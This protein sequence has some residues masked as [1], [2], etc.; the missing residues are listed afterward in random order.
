MITIVVPV[1]NE[2]SNITPLVEEIFDAAKDLP[3]REVLFVDDSSTDGSWDILKKL[4]SRY[5]TLNIIR[6]KHNHGQSAALWTGIKAAENDIIVTLDGDGQNPP[7]DIKTLWDAYHRIK[8]ESPRVMIAGERVKRNDTWIRRASSRFA[9]GLRSGL[10]KD[11][12][13]DTGCSLKLF[14]RSDY[15]A[16]PYFDHMHRF[17]PALM[18]RDGVDI[19]HVPVSHRPR[20]H[21]VS[22][23]GTLDRALVGIVDLLGVLW[24]QKRASGNLEYESI[25]PS[26]QDIRQEI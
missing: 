8:K 14:R 20:V 21:G 25:K 5:P 7:S 1:Y 16:L 24:L 6:H 13:R 23:Y 18:I 15:L 19:L 22:K 12:T 4:S 26:N 9:N 11:R 17:L 2:E 3:V 10:L